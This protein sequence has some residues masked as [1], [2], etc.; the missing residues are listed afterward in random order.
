MKTPG[1][2]DKVD[3]F[4]IWQEKIGS[5]DVSFYIKKNPTSENVGILNGNIE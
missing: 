3:I 4:S 5:M 2:P 1:F